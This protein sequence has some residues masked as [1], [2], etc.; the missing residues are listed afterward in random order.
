MFGGPHIEI[1]AYKILGDW[2]EGSGWTT[3]ICDAGIASSGVA[4]SL[5]KAA[6][7]TRTRHPHQLK[8]AVLY[9]P[10]TPAYKRYI[11]SIPTDEDPLDFKAWSTKMFTDQPQLQYWSHVLEFELCIFRLVGSFREANFQRYVDI[12]KCFTAS[13]TGLCNCEENYFQEE[14]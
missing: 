1:A 9:I 6:H 4:D 14:L 10:R 12:C 7:V 2:L 8:A 13:C 3:A 11:K 5:F